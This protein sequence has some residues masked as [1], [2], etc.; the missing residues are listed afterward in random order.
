MSPSEVL[1][2]TAYAF[3]MISEEE[4]ADKVFSLR[5]ALDSILDLLS[6]V[7]VTLEGKEPDK[8]ELLWKERGAHQLYYFELLFFLG[9]SETLFGLNFEFLV[10]I[11]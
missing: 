6:V 8:E 7:N 4:G 11:I 3:K 2:S 9:C 5:R 1:I 10:N